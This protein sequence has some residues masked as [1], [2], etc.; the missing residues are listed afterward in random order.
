MKESAAD[1]SVELGWVIFAAQLRHTTLATEAVFVAIDHVFGG[2]GF[3]RLEWTCTAEYVRSRRTADRLGFSFEGIMRHKLV[4][5]GTAR[6]IAMYS[7][8]ADEWA[9]RR[10]D[11]L[12]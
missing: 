4:L 9:V 12:A 5:K 6:D 11:F 3:S 1:G 7:L 10:R 8:L 2:L